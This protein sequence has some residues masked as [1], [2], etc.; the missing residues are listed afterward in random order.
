[1]TCVCIGIYVT[2]LNYVH[3][4]TYIYIFSELNFEKLVKLCV[5]CETDKFKC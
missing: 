4:E 1:M 3:P 2:R 5:L